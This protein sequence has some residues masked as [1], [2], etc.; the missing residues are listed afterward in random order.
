VDRALVALLDFK[1]SGRRE[2]R[3]RW[4]RFPCT[5]ATFYTKQLLAVSYQH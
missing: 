5:S 2:Q 4:V 3:L 1:S